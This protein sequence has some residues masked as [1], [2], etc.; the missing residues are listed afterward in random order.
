MFLAGSQMHVV[1]R[2]VASRSN[3]ALISAGKIV[4]ARRIART[5]LSL[6]LSLVERTS[7]SAAILAQSS[8]TP[9][10]HAP[11]KRHVLPSSL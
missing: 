2:Y 8:A 9:L 10:M 5:Q 4:I 1:A 6:A 11:R 3:A 7:R